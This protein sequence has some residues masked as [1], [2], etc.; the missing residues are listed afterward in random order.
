LRDGYGGNGPW[1]VVAGM[2]LGGALV[3]AGRK[4]AEATS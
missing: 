4:K 2:L 3:L 1:G